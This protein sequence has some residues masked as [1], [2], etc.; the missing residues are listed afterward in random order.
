VTINTPPAEKPEFLPLYAE[1][2]KHYFETIQLMLDSGEITLEQLLSNPFAFIPRRQ[3]PE[4]LAYYELCKKILP[5]PGCVVEVG[6]YF[7]NGLMIWAKLLETLIP[8]NRGRKV[9]GFDDF[10]GYTRQ[11]SEFDKPGIEHIQ[12]RYG[13]NQNVF[14]VKQATIEK[15]V[16]L[17]NI[18]T[19]LPGVDRAILYSGNLKASLEAFKK[20]EPG[21]RIA[22]LI[23]DVNLYIPT[24]TA[25]EQLFDRVIWGGFI[26]LRGYGVKPWEGESKAVDEFIR[27]HHSE[28]IQD[29]TF[30]F[31]IYPAII[32]RKEFK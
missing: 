26:V 18:D 15:L 8:G 30:S 22:M 28:L 9:F 17:N 31:S 25:L 24:V 32:L 5:L 16:M 10:D 7:G 2:D 3:I 20:D 29:Q 6:V 19:L 4:L 21:M 23:I 13:E 27:G 11:I 14:K 1:R 12:K